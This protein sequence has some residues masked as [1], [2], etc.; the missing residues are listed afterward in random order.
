MR[1]WLYCSIY[2][3]AN[4]KWSIWLLQFMINAMVSTVS[5]LISIVSFLFLYSYVMFDVYSYVTFIIAVVSLLGEKSCGYYAPLPPMRIEN[6]LFSR[7][8]CL[9]M[10]WLLLLLIWYNLYLLLFVVFMMRLISIIPLLSTLRWYLFWGNNPVITIL[11]FT[12]RE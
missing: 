12:W 7:W 6:Y 9:L 1:W 10:L 11:C 4:R 5:D 3:H 8:C 2:S